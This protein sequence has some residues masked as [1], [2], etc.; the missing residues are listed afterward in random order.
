MQLDGGSNSHVL[1]DKEN[2]VQYKEIS[3]NIQQISGST[4]I[5][6]G[7]RLAII[8]IPKTEL[9]IPLWPVYYMPHNHQSTFSQN[10]IKSYKKIRCVHT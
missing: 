2:F 8:K 1:T 6:V 3:V 9:I 10:A 5:A 7:Y 4:A